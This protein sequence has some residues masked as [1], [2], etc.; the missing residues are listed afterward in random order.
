MPGK[1]DV[2]DDYDLESQRDVTLTS[3]T[4]RSPV[5]E[6]GLIKGSGVESKGVAS[7]I[8]GRLAI[9][10]AGQLQKPDVVQQPNGTGELSY[11]VYIF[12]GKSIVNIFNHVYYN[13]R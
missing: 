3:Y 9:V 13:E 4:S 12:G 10:D 2:K 11:W 6:L 5:D 8:D 7:E 1:Y